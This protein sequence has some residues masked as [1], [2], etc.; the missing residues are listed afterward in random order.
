MSGSSGA[1][2]ELAAFAAGLRFEELPPQV[3]R[4]LKSLVLDSL[5][6]AVAA[7]TLGDGCAELL[8]MAAAGAPAECTLLGAGRKSSLLLAALANGGLVHALNYDASSGAGHLGL[9]PA[10]PLALAEARGGCSGRDLLSALAAGCE[11]TS[12]LAL[13]AAAAQTS[14]GMGL[15]GQV[16]GYFGVAAACGR[17]MELETERMH[18][19][20]GLALM[21]TA[22]SRQVG[23]E[24]DPPAKAIYGAFPNQGGLVAALLAEQGTGAQVAA[25]EGQ[26]GVF[27]LFYRGQFAEAIL[28]DGLGDAFRL[29]GVQLKRWPTSGIAMPFVQAAL[30][31]RNELPGPIE[32]I[33]ATAGPWARD[34]LE[35]VEERRRPGTIS[36]AAN[37]I[38]YGVCKAL[39]NG[40]LTL[41]D[42]TAEGLRQPEPLALAARM[43]HSIDE[44]CTSSG[45][46]EIRSRGGD[47]R[48][49]HIERDGVRALDWPLLADKFR[50]CA[51]FA[52]QPL[53]SE[54]IDEIIASV[55][56]LERLA[57]VRL[58]LALF[59][60]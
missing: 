40:D 3:V 8:R 19:A 35:P 37:S 23:L 1:T 4:V 16:M 59:G 41:P 9:V 52:A 12:R 56:S 54:R 58:L 49:A 47:R 14:R 17:L 2:R 42:F 48:V 43:T 33:H 46:L 13:S 36:S 27:G 30:D 32:A 6:T 10:A 25:F 26:A 11:I 7:S 15:D 44:A 55:D 28:G 34:W 24:G 29:V 38:Y 31:L 18:S 22:G 57:D 60:D 51:R 45:S 5:G 20:L 21:Q 53:A 50:D 39:T